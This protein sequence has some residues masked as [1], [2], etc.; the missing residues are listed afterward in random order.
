MAVIGRGTKS[1][2]RHAEDPVGPECYLALEVQSISIAG[3]WGKPIPV[4]LGCFDAEC[5]EVFYHQKPLANTT[6][7]EQRRMS[8]VFVMIF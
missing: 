8:S 6:P 5:V 4:S 1:R 3:L 2:L 7:S